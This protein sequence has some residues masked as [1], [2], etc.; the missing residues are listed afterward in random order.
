MNG[1]RPGL[2]DARDLGTRMY[3]SREQQFVGVDIPDPGD[4]R[5]I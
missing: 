4:K 5:L 1:L 3:A 2:R